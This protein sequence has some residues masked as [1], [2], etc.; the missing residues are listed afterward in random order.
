MGLYELGRLRLIFL[1]TGIAIGK[2]SIF[3]EK[4]KF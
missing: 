1:D 3:R 4:S 2:H